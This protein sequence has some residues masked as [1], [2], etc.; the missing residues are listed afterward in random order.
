MIAL[1]LKKT[2][3]Q[4]CSINQFSSIGRKMQQDQKIEKSITDPLVSIIIMSYNEEQYI[5]RAI[6]SVLNQTYS[7]FELYITDDGS[8]DNT[9]H[10]IEKTVQE[11]SSDQRISFI[12]YDKNQGFAWHDDII[13]LLKGKYICILGGDDYY[14]DTK[15]SKQVA[16]LEKNPEYAGCFTWLEIEC[17]KNFNIEQVKP[18]E[19]SINIDH[20][21]RFKL[22][23][24]LLTVGNCIPAPSMMV[25]M[26]IYKKS[27]GYNWGYRLIQ[28]YALWLRLLCEF[29]L[30]II[31][32]KLTHYNIRKGSLSNSYSSQSNALLN[33]EIEDVKYKLLKD[34]DDEVF[35]KVFYPSYDIN[36]IMPVEIKCLKFLMFTKSSDP[37]MQQV[38][39]RLYHDY[40]YD[41]DFNRVLSND[42]EL[43]RTK[44]HDYI[45]HTNIY[46][47]V[48]SSFSNS[49]P[50][51][52]NGD[53]TLV[54][55]LLDIIDKISDT[56]VSDKHI[57]ALFRVCQESEDSTEKFTQIIN[58]LANRN[59]LFSN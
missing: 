19:T 28:D 35:L 32:Q 44:I 14:E 42:Y 48:L 53:I 36:A 41:E 23:N 6:E 46:K 18:L 49:A 16:F 7:N 1:F 51:D 50:T 10:V 58:E 3:N 59:M 40:M 12:K 56:R 29:P 34:M 20:Y 27:G 24:R 31:P 15:I 30:A 52:S 17:D 21:D 37:I 8:T 13:P 2:Y 9:A 26:D 22:L 33:C 39:I 45:S 47:S 38:A 43:I 57:S 11:Y 25:N 55:E 5:K 4:K 54:N